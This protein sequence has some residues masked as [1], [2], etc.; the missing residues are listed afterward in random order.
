MGGPK[1]AAVPHPDGTH[2]LVYCTESPESWFEDFGFGTLANGGAKI[3]IDP[4]FAPL[5]HTDAYHVFLSERDGHNDLF[6]S[7]VTPTGFEVHAAKNST[8]ATGTFSYRLVAKRADI[9]A[10][11]LAVYTPSPKMQVPTVP[12]PVRH[13]EQERKR[14]QASNARRVTGDKGASKSM[15]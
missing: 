5:I 11:R 1:N 6:V 8:T 14:I 15:R 7:N 12:P 9:E 13:L 10:P 2:R 3:A 4:H